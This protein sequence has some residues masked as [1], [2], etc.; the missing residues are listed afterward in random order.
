MIEI[1]AIRLAGGEGHENIAELMWRSAA[2]SVGRCTRQAIVDWLGGSAMNRAVVEVSSEVV[3]LAVVGGPDE[4][5]HLRA[6]RDGAWTDDLL[7][8]PRF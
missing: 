3:E 8:L 6:R 4:P 7:A 5:P 1:T 2:T